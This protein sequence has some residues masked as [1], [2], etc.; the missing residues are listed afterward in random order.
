MRGIDKEKT[1]GVRRVGGRGGDL[2]TVTIDAQRFRKAQLCTLDSSEIVR[3]YGKSLS[4]VLLESCGDLVSTN[5]H[6]LYYSKNKGAK[7]QNRFSMVIRLEEIIDEDSMELVLSI[8]IKRG[9]VRTK[10]DGVKGSRGVLLRDLFPRYR[11][12]LP[13]SK[14]KRA[15]ISHIVL[16]PKYIELLTSLFGGSVILNF[17][18][19][20]NY[21]II[22]KDRV[23]DSRSSEFVLLQPMTFEKVPDDEVPF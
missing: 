5:R 9:T 19:E 20:E 6:I 8:N 13:D 17:N 4:G 15:S 10:I 18:G 2:V 11:A 1:A 23:Y 3:G 7:D 14:Q 22:T 12:L 21:V 16:N